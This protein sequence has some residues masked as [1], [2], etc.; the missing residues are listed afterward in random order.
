MAVA[1]GADANVVIALLQIK[2]AVEDEPEFE[3]AA[4]EVS[5]QFE[6]AN[7]GQAL[8]SR[9]FENGPVLFVGWGQLFEL[10][11]VAAVVGEGFVEPGA[12]Q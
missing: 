3:G 9:R 1:E 6:V 11:E 7:F 2:S 12:G 5:E 4:E 10:G 8:P